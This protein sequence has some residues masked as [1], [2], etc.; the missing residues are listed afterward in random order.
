MRTTATLFG[1]LACVAFAQGIRQERLEGGVL[2]P[3]ADGPAKTT[4]T[5]QNLVIANQQCMNRCVNKKENM[6]RWI[7]KN[8]KKKSECMHRCS[9]ECLVCPLTAVQHVCADK[10]KAQCGEK[11]SCIH[12]C[13]EACPCEDVSK[14]LKNL[15]HLFPDSET[16]LTFSRNPTA[17]YAPGKKPVS[18]AGEPLVTST[19]GESPPQDGNAL[20]YP[21]HFLPSAGH[22]LS[23]APKAA[24]LKLIKVATKKSKVTDDEKKAKDSESAADDLEA[25]KEAAKATGNV[26]KEKDLEKKASAM[27]AVA[28][29][30]SAKGVP[31]AAEE[32]NAAD[33]AESE[34]N[35]LKSQDKAAELLKQANEASMNGEKGKAGELRALAKTM[36]ATAVKDEGMANAKLKADADA[37]LEAAEIAAIEAE[38]AA[39]VAEEKSKDDG[40]I[41]KLKKVAEEKRGIAEKMKEEAKD[42]NSVD[43]IAAEEGAAL[44]K[45]AGNKA[46]LAI[47]LRAQAADATAK[48]NLTAATSLQQQADVADMEAKQ[49]GAEAIDGAVA[50]K[51]G[52]LLAEAEKLAKAAEEARKSGDMAVFKKLER[53][54][55][56]AE[57]AADDEKDAASMSAKAMS[58]MQASAKLRA[59]AEKSKKANDTGL[60]SA[61]FQSA[62][63]KAAESQE[64]QLR[65][66]TVIM[67]KELAK[68]KRAIKILTTQ[69]NS[70]LDQVLSDSLGLEI[71]KLQKA[72]LKLEA[73]R[74]ITN[75]ADAAHQNLKDA[76]AKV[77]DAS[78]SGKD[79]EQIALLRVA[80]SNAESK[81]GNM[82]ADALSRISE[83]EDNAEK[84]E[85]NATSADDG[86]NEKI[87]L[88][89]S[90]G[91]STE[92]NELEKKKSEVNELVEDAML[93]LVPNSAAA[94]ND[95]AAGWWN[96]WDRTNVTSTSLHKLADKM[97]D[98][99]H[100]KDPGLVQ[101]HVDKSEKHSQ[102]ALEHYGKWKDG[103]SE[104]SATGATGGASANASGSANTT[105]VPIKGEVKPGSSGASGPSF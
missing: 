69:Q 66:Q 59:E 93:G 43:S 52:K 38:K 24:F 60:A 72:L 92:Q 85:E 87:E 10:C 40:E 64:A 19:G 82:T 41:E 39:D 18:A 83:S 6:C 86:L 81:A 100:N 13:L 23:K 89:K 54:Q 73:S 53:R 80:L 103:D 67:D 2:E 31:G 21:I 78:V 63:E 99:V 61:L 30:A 71:S 32:G 8:V 17:H 90:I 56:A 11:V 35:A 26:E 12:S 79:K 58:M 37:A 9:R 76:Q 55:K 74:T 36:K 104:K 91:N 25:E 62:R 29:E 65:S 5:E 94:G 97:V 48:G 28:K 46:A 57:T 68:L 105:F 50:A 42:A 70:T 51:S 45:A 1:V 22:K 102:E 27:R 84:L 95:T 88:A 47:K 14:E 7:T 96:K 49:E 20:G 4:T 101:L 44:K 3:S 34:V 33:E 16:A 15:I 98:E 77:E 75:E